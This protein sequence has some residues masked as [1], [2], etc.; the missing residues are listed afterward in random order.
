MAF[1][2]RAMTL[3]P[4]SKLANRGHARQAVPAI[5][6]S[7]QILLT[8]SFTLTKRPVSIS[9]LGGADV[10]A[11]ATLSPNSIDDLL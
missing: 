9:D 3:L 4:I 10:F 6:P 5:Y 2:L 8:K 1:Q 11:T 7:G